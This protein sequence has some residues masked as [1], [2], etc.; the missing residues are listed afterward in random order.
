MLEYSEPKFSKRAYFEII[1]AYADRLKLFTQILPADPVSWAVLR[2]D[3]EFSPSRALVLARWD[4]EIGVKSHFFFQ[5]K[6]SAYNV[7]DEGNA[8]LIQVIRSLGHE[9]CLHAY[10]LRKDPVRIAALEQE[11][12]SQKRIL[13]IAADSDVDVF[14]FHRPP[15]WVLEINRDVLGGMINAYGP[16]FF[17][18]S[19]SPKKIRYI[20]DSRH[21]FD[22]GHP[23]EVISAPRVQLNFHPDEWSEWG[24]TVEE[25]FETLY[26]LGTRDYLKTLLREADHFREI[27]S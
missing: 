20:A 12:E 11:L 4:H 3:V 23:L 24:S 19:D 26:E 1:E 25:N 9:V 6:S 27:W 21:R 17:E 5:T 2:H 14:S 8:H 7:C 18:F 16:T 22:Y 15:H 10:V 13:E